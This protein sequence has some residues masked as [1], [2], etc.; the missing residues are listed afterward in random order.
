MK[1]FPKHVTAAFLHTWEKALSDELTDVANAEQ[2]RTSRRSILQILTGLEN[3][4]PVIVINAVMPLC[5][6]V[7]FHDALSYVS[8]RSFNLLIL[9]SL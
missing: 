8:G 3:A 4:P 1:K 7:F 2:H 5:L 6:S 9:T